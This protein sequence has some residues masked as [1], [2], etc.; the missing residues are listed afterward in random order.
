MSRVDSVFRTEA[1]LLTFRASREELVGLG[2]SHLAFGLIATWIVGMGRWWDDPNA[3][4]VQQ[5][6]IGSLVY[7]FV[8]AF[9]LWLL[10]KPLRPADWSYRG[11]LTFV[12]LT[13]PPAILYAIPVERFLDLDAA[14]QIN[15]WFL[16]LVATW[17]VGLL[18]FYLRRLARLPWYAV[19]VATLLPLTVIVATLAALNLERAVFDVMGGLREEG[20]ASDGA[21]GVLVALTLVSSML[22]VPLLIVYVLTWY[23]RR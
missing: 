9:L 21:Y 4:L 14:R 17:R 18:A 13:S 15:V 16:G 6:G 10:I 7:V 2:K 23:A 3:H 1:R 5:L 12:A 11:V 22:V 20:T 19:L 8:L